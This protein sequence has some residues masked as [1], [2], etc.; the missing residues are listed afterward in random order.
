MQL[1]KMLNIVAFN[2]A[3]TN[4]DVSMMCVLNNLGTCVAVQCRM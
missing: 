1:A 2:Q 3:N 4:L